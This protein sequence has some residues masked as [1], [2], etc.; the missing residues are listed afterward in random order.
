MLFGTSSLFIW[1]DFV[2]PA[3]LTENGRNG[4]LFL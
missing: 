3:P 2:K 4:I 1:E